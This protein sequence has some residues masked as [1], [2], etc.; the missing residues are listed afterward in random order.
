MYT[1]LGAT[2]M[3]GRDW[4]LLLI[5]SSLDKQI[6]AQAA[7][8]PET[9]AGEPWW[10][11]TRQLLHP[12]TLSSSLISVYT[13][14]YIKPALIFPFLFFF[15]RTLYCLMDHYGDTLSGRLKHWKAMSF[16]SHSWLDEG[17]FMKPLERTSFQG[18]ATI[19]EMLALL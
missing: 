17:M 14:R 6:E 18:L 1:Q 5:G 16:W 11:G 3:E 8:P 9:L 7:A 15:L 4:N 13:L 10:V 19:S 12:V 2:V